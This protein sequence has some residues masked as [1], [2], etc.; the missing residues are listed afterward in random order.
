MIKCR[1]SH[2]NA[3]DNYTPKDRSIYMETSNETEASY[4][5]LK[6]AADRLYASEQKYKLLIGYMNEISSTIASS[7]I[8]MNIRTLF[9]NISVKIVNTI[10]L[11]LCSIWLM[12]EGG[13]VNCMAAAGELGSKITTAPVKANI[14]AF[15]AVSP[16]IDV[17]TFTQ[18]CRKYMNMFQLSSLEESMSD[19]LLFLPFFLNGMPKGTLVVCSDTSLDEDYVGLLR[20][21]TNNLA[22]AVEKAELYKKFKQDY[23]KTI[24]GLIAAIEAKDTYTQGHSIRVSQY[25]VEIA[26]EMGLSSEEVEEIEIAGILHDIG[27]IGIS[28]SILT[29]P[30]IL[31]PC[32]FEMV[33]EH[34]AIGRR[35]LQPIGLSE[36]IINATLLHHKRY[37]LKGYPE[38]TAV[39]ELPLIANIIC[40]A[41]A[42]D[43]M[44][45]YRSYKSPMARKEAIE[46]LKNCSGTQFCPEI[47]ETMERLY[48]K[49]LI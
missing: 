26:R 40:V 45:S 2:D 12:D 19:K 9:E 31:E 25:A 29:K 1:C 20:S 17:H 18:A 15:G 36:N 10:G 28:D 33:K 38:N 24:M 48:N 34:P 37:D 42:Y 3:S 16:D 30:G 21:I 14:A 6:S 23:L 8:S 39:K 32:E 41:D 22:F 5:Q 4:N 46:E 43:A 44:T 49:K 13:N 35:I 47:V 27:K 11:T 7:D